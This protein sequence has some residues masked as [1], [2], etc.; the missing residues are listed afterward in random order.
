MKEKAGNGPI[1]ERL[2]VAGGTGPGRRG[3]HQQSSASC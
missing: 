1:R 3:D 2:R